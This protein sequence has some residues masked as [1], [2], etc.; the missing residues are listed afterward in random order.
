MST[1][2]IGIGANLGDRAATIRASFAL[3]AEHP[4]VET[5]AVSRL[6][7]TAPV[8]GTAGQPN[9]LNAAARLATSLAPIALLELLQEIEH[10]CGRRR[11]ERWSARTLDLDLLLYG[12][13][14]V[15]DVRLEVPHPRMTFRR[16]VLQPAAEVASDMVHP[17]MGW[18]VARLLDHLDAS[19]LY[20]AL[21]GGTAEWRT[22]LADELAASCAARLVRAPS[23]DRSSPTGLSAGS[24]LESLRAQ[25]R[26]LAS[27]SWPDVGQLAVSDFWFDQWPLVA[28]SRDPPEL[29]DAW[30]ELRGDVV[31]P[32]LTVLPAAPHV[33]HDN[34]PA[35]PT[36]VLDL[37]IERYAQHPALGPV[38]VV[39]ANDWQLTVEES[40]AACR[41]MR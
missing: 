13:R 18:T 40:V 25:A 11:G 6:H 32:R 29:G 24:T 19:L 33:G 9:F 1:C 39:P 2:L 37:A 16:F 28:D 12:D 35:P 10:R 36:N 38:L 5:I 17:R 23:A 3:L 30:Q 31:V 26:A 22:R 21:G 7:E 4:S 34:R 41:A 27:A 20:I 15:S 8:G 14:V